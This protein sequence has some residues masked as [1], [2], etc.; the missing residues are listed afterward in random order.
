MKKMM[1]NV[2]VVT[3]AALCLSLP[4]VISSLKEQHFTADQLPTNAQRYVA[5]D[6]SGIISKTDKARYGFNIALSSNAYQSL[7]TQGYGD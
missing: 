4:I 2:K 5:N 1:K 3:F 6:P 7:R